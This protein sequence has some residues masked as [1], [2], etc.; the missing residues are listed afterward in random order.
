MRCAV[1][2]HNVVAFV[3][4]TA[5]K[6]VQSILC[7]FLSVQVHSLCPTILAVFAMLCNALP[8]KYC[9][10][11]D[12]LCPTISAVCI[13]SLCNISPKYFYV[14]CAKVFQRSIQIRS[15]R[16]YWQ[17][18]QCIVPVCSNCTLLSL[19]ALNIKLHSPLL[20]VPIILCWGC[21]GGLQCALYCFQLSCGHVV[22]SESII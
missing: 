15:V 6:C 4:Y 18:L 14:S 16:Q 21:I 5:S 8:E 17:Y 11:S 9:S 3:S 20:S 10:S 7:A 1:A 12:P 19:C 13:V 2:D 22:L